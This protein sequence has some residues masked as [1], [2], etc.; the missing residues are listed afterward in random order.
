MVLPP[1]K[2]PEVLPARRRR[3]AAT[4][5]STQVAH[6]ECYV[7]VAVVAAAA[8]LELVAMVDAGEQ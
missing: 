1:Q 7:P 8:E 5:V 4:K 3:R 6:H 2:R